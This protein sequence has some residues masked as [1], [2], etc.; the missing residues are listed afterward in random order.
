MSIAYQLRRIEFQRSCGAKQKHLSWG[1]AAAHIRS[2]VRRFDIDP[3]SMAIYRC[4]WCQTFH[5]G[6]RRR[7]T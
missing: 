1:K 3:N 4:K 5:V 2:L 6:H 7:A